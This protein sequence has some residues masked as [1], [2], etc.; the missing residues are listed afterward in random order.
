MK[1][2]KYKIQIGDVMFEANDGKI[3]LDEIKR[4]VYEDLAIIVEMPVWREQ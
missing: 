1:K 3:T 4:R 2:D